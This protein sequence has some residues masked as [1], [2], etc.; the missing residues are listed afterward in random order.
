M[1][2][3]SGSRRTGD[4]EKKR[5]VHWKAFEISD[6][7]EVRHM[8]IRAVTT[9]NRPQVVIAVCLEHWEQKLYSRCVY[10]AVW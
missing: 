10:M 6:H 4:E 3:K 7:F 5:D 9:E 8:G 2:G 1:A